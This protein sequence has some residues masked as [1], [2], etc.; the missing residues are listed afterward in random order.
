LVGE[1]L[2]RRHPTPNTR[3]PTPIPSPLQPRIEDPD[4][5]VA[6]NLDPRNAQ[7]TMVHVPLEAMGI[8][9]DQPYVVHDLITGARFTWTG[10][11][12]YVRLDPNDQVAHVL[13]VER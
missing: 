6:V 7:A 2:F 11:R 9:A 4:I 5:L 13:R 8:A 3:H 10:P 1:E 12:N